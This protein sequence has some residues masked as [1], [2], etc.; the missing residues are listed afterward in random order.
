MTAA[1]TPTH[2]CTLGSEGKQMSCKALQQVYFGSTALPVL[3]KRD[4]GRR[5]IQ[6]PLLPGRTPALEGCK[7]L[8]RIARQRG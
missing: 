4:G 8:C 2:A 1:S 7:A 3:W 6:S 5:D